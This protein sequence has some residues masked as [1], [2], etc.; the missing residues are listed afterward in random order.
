MCLCCQFV[1]QLLLS[2]ILSKACV[3]FIDEFEDG[4]NMK[5]IGTKCFKQ[6]I[7]VLEFNYSKNQKEPLCS[8]H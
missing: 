7:F 1:E 3:T 8:H 6:Y 2:S 5:A 4:F